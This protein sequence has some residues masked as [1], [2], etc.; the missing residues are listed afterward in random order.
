MAGGGG[1]GKEGQKKGDKMRWI[2]KE[3]RMKDTVRSE[4][5]GYSLLSNLQ[6]ARYCP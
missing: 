1:E 5:A 2:K 3:G 6:T 4:L